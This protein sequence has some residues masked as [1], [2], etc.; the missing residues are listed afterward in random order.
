MSAVWYAVK[1]GIYDHGLLGIFDTLGAAQAACEQHTRGDST[2]DG[3]GY[4][5]YV[6]YVTDINEKGEGEIVGSWKSVPFRGPYQWVDAKE[7]RDS[8]KT[9]WTILP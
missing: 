8:F 1:R 3:D 5:E 4:H 6:V 2:T 9:Q 7:P